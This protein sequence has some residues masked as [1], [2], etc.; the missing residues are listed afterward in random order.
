MTIDLTG[1]T[2]LVTGSTEGIGFAIAKGLAEAGASVIVNGRRP[3]KI[4]AAVAKIG[5]L[6]RVL[7]GDGPQRR[8]LKLSSKLSQTWTS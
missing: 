7:V 2:A 5:K 4:S 8:S 6:A 3:E 1:K